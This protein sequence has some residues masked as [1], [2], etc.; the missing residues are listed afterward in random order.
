MS[1][2]CELFLLT[3]AR[4]MGVG[5]VGGSSMP[6]QGIA[7]SLAGHADADARLRALAVAAPGAVRQMLPHFV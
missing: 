5:S 6:P 4:A 2:P 7:H 1:V 3:V